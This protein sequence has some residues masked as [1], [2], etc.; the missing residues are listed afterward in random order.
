M[1]PPKSPSPP[2]VQLYSNIHPVNPMPSNLQALF[3]PMT[4]NRMQ[5]PENMNQG[6]QFPQVFYV[7]VIQTLKLIFTADQLLIA[8]TV[9][10]NP[11]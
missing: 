3:P 10:L 5:D 8:N 6:Y 7:M 2:L 11:I 1:K 4:A 9:M